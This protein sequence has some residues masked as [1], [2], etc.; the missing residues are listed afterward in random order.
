M[1]VIRSL[2]LSHPDRLLAQVETIRE[3]AVAFAAPQ[4][5]TAL[6]AGLFLTFGFQMLLTNLSVATGISV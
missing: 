2:F 3:T 4:F 5:L 6:I 1:L